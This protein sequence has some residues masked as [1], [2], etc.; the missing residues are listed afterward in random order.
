MGFSQPLCAIYRREFANAA[1]NALRAG[2]YKI[3]PLFSVVCTRVIEQEELQ[4]AGFSASM[5]RNLNTPEELEKE[6]ESKVSKVQGFK[7]SGTKN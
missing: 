1:E 4:A 5:F 7:V 6:A 3:D 2:R